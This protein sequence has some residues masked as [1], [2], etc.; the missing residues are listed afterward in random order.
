M[1][2]YHFFGRD[3]GYDIISSKKGYVQCLKF[4]KLRYFSIRSNLL[5]NAFFKGAELGAE[6]MSYLIYP[7][8]TAMLRNTI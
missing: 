2:L 7:N 4:K 3:R 8:F 6:P 5:R 1:I